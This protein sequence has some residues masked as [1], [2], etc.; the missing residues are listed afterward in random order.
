[1]RHRVPVRT[2]TPLRR[3][4]LLIAFVALPAAPAAAA[5]TLAALKPCYVSVL[6][7]A[8][9]FE[10]EPVPV[11]G[12]GFTP[13]ALVDVTVGDG[14]PVIT[15]TV[16]ADGNL[17]AGAVKPPVVTFFGQQPFTITA[18]ERSNPA[19]TAS[20]DSRVS[21]LS[22]RARP[23]RARPSSRV[24]FTGRGFTDPAAPVYA[25]YVLHGR[26]RRTV[27]VVRRPAGACG[28]FSVRRRQFPFRPKT[29]SWTVQFDQRRS[30]MANPP[31]VQLAIDV[32]RVPRTRR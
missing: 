8:K 25:H 6:T 20:T 7:V 16:G 4:A 31:F 19:Q 15:L 2:V 18:T 1:M 22:V 3:T 30:F 24:R 28:T 32:R 21:R 14:L 27:R 11:S 13:G 23:G 9:T 17:P 29:G 26:L 10:T 5:P 12:S